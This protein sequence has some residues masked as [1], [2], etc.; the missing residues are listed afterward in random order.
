MPPSCVMEVSIAYEHHESLEQTAESFALDV[1]KI[2]KD[3]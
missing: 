1:Y 2:L 3:L